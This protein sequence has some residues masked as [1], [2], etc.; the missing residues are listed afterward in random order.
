MTHEYE[1]SQTTKKSP[2]TNTKQAVC[3][4]PC[5]IINRAKMSGNKPA[6]KKISSNDATPFNRKKP[7]NE[8]SN[9]GKTRNK[10]KIN[11]QSNIKTKK[12][13]ARKNEMLGIEAV[14]DLVA[15]FKPGMIVECDILKFEVL[16]LLGSGAFG[17]VYCCCETN[18][19]TEYAMKIEMIP[20]P[21]DNFLRC[22][23]WEEEILLRLQ[24]FELS[25][26]KNFAS[27]IDRGTTG[28]NKF[29]IMVMS[30]LGKSLID[31]KK[32]S[33]LGN[34]F[35]GNTAWKIGYQ[36]LQALE[37]FH[38]AGFVHR[39]LKPHNYS[40]GVKS[41]DELVY[42]F[43]FGLVRCYT[44]KVY[45][46]AIPEGAGTLGTLKYMSLASH[47]S[48][49]QY[50]KDDIE[51]WLYT[52]MDLYDPA[53]LVWGNC[54]VQTDVG[55]AKEAL[56]SANL[57]KNIFT[58]LPNEYAYLIKKVGQMVLVEPVSKRPSE[59]K[60]IRYESFYMILDR[61][62]EKLGYSVNKPFDWNTPQFLKKMKK[63]KE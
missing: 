47:N 46:T 37:F 16:N 23:P 24:E 54:T 60:K 17:S 14:R 19:R 27:L 12:K 62:C 53:S 63:P 32:A 57:T 15:G 11:E 1:G 34:R 2:G 13:S 10:K 18:S 44:G 30:L 3:N 49:V 59:V 40:S 61:I 29:R 58:F 55:R 7:Q 52:L 4:E 28:D 39:D 56:L 42:V 9:D 20:G 48:V 41:S 51:C 6:N 35:S 22:L 38:Q 33:H 5:C 8:T 25:K 50:P 21:S 36:T 43:D 45:K 26:R 31:W